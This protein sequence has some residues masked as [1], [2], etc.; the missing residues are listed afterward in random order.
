MEK[1]VLINFQRVIFMIEFVI[2]V[3]IGT[4]ASAIATAV[5]RYFTEPEMIG[6]LLVDKTDP[7]QT[8]LYLK[9]ETRAPE[10]IAELKYVEMKVKIVD[11]FSDDIS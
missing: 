8:N 9:L 3:V 6:A 4:A 1:Q 2:G 11:Y 5:I 10:E 7:Q